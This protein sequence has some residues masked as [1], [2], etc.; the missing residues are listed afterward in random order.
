MNKYQRAIDRMKEAGFSEETVDEVIH[1]PS[2]RTHD[3]YKDF[4][5]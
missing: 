3:K 2:L 4:F 1:I 5:E